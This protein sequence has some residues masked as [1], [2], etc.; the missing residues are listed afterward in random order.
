MAIRFAIEG[1]LRFVSHHD[2]M[3]LFERAL[4]RAQL[5][6]KFTE[7]FNPRPKLSLPLPRSVG[8]ASEAE[9]LVVGLTEPVEPAAVQAR[10]AEQMV[11]DLTLAEAW[12]DQG[13]A[14]LQAEKVTYCVE[15]P[16]GRV[17]EV[18]ETVDRLLDA[19]T[20]MVERAGPGDRPG[21][22][23]DLTAFLIE[24]TVAD[25]RLRWTSRVTPAGSL[26][27]AELLSA[28]GLDPQE[29]LHRVRRTSVQWRTSASD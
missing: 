4:A 16:Q 21:K 14:P 15:V 29:H 11:A 2:L 25:G 18:R 5:P 27:P 9:V 28:A 26:R 17:E 1:D 19:E 23:I 24:A 20:W 3:R 13:R 6:V 8:I 12:E 10:L 7:G 22:R